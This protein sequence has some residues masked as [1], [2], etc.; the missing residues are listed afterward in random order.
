MNGCEADQ[1]EERALFNQHG[2]RSPLVFQAGMFSI[3]PTIISVGSG[4][5]LMGAVS[6]ASAVLLHLLQGP[7][8]TLT[9]NQLH[10]HQ[11]GAFFCDMV[12][13]YLIKKK[14]SYRKWKFEGCG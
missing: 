7:A 11:Q 2:K 8:V 12:L 6:R 3:V 10:L 4:V 9:S 13:L 1:G 5:A 14:D